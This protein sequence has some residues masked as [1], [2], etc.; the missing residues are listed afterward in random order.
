MKLYWPHWNLRCFGVQIGSLYFD[1]SFPP[2][3]GFGWSWGR[4]IRVYWKR[5]YLYLPSC[6]RIRKAYYAELK[7]VYVRAYGGRQQDH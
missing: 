7:R 1:I 2:L 6:R 3:E 4:L 5:N